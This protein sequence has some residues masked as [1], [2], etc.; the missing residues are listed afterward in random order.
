M[1]TTAEEI[2]WLR[3]L[4]QDPGVPST[5]P[6]PLHCDNTDTIQITLNLVKFSLSKHIGVDAFFL[7][8]QYGLGTLVPLY[9]PSEQQLADLMTKPQTR[10]QHDYLLSKLSMYDPP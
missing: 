6:T 1:A 10:A 8:D 4:L 9:V 5:D 3:W 2:I 7:R